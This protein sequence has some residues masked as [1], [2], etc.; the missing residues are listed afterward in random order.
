L[1]ERAARLGAVLAER[2]GR[3]QAAA[4]G[5]ITHVASAGLVAALQFTRP[6]T[7]EPAPAP[8]W[9]F[10]WEAVKRGIM[11]FAPVGVGGSAVKLNPP[12]AIEDAALAEGLDVLEEV[13]GLL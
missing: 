5:K 12:L 4:R 11:L 13:A 6:G 8:A 10:V 3:I 7:T 1:I 9:A 2:A